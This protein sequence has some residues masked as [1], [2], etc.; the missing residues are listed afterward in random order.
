MLAVVIRKLSQQF[1]GPLQGPQSLM[2]H[3]HVLAPSSCW[4]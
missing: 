3:R 2:W 1:A 4:K